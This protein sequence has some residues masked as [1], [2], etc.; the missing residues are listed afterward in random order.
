MKYK[1][2]SYYTLLLSLHSTIYMRQDGWREKN[3][4]PKTSVIWSIAVLCISH[5][6]QQWTSPVVL[7]TWG[8]YNTKVLACTTHLVLIP[9]ALRFPLFFTSLRKELLRLLIFLTTESLTL[10]SNPLTDLMSFAYDF[11]FRFLLLY[12]LLF[13]FHKHSLDLYMSINCNNCS[14]DHEV[15]LLPHYSPSSHNN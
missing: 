2:E 3:L 1:T 10:G 11:S 14:F 9:K 5:S 12:S 7:G 4:T 8:C 13:I 15:M 6:H